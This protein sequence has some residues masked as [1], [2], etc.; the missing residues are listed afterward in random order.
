MLDVSEEHTFSSGT[1]S[2][3]S[4]SSGNILCYLRMF[5][6]VA[7]RLMQRDRGRRWVLVAYRPGSLDPGNFLKYLI[8]SGLDSLQG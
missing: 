2:K 1:N 3:P 7:M 6:S 4:S 8:E 5:S